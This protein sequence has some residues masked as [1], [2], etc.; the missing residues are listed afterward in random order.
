MKTQFNKKFNLE[1]SLHAIIQ[2]LRVSKKINTTPFQAHFGRTCNTPISN[3]TTQSNNNNNLNY[4]KIIQHY[5][6]E[7]TIPGR[8]YLTKAQWAD[9]ALCCNTEIEKLICAANNRAQKVKEKMKDGESRLIWSERLAR[10]IP[11]SERP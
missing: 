6:D 9:T 2:R 5:L 4:N 1:Q 7:D 8:F 10:P 11:C 3:I